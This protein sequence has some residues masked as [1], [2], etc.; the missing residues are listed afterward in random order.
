MPI[1]PDHLDALDKRAAELNRDDAWLCDRNFG[2]CG[3]FSEFKARKEAKEM[4]PHNLKIWAMVQAQVAIIE[5][6]KA[7]NRGRES[8]GYAMAYDA[9]SFF[10]AAQEMERLAESFERD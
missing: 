3:D 5:G 10:Q 9:D 7:E 4:S 1:H 8:N 2:A 6:M